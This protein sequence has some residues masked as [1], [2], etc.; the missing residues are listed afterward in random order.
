MT[1]LQ[2]YYRALGVNSAGGWPLSLFLTPDAKPLGG[3]TYF[4]PTDEEGRMGFPSLMKRVVQSWSEKRKE[5][6]NNAEYLT[7]AVRETMRPRAVLKPPKLEAAIVSNIVNL[8][9]AT[10]DP[11]HGG[12]GF[13]AA[14]PRRPKF[15]VPTKLAL[16]Q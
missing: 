14:E 4:P 10:Y 7:T 12:F 5:M 16:L 3:G 8:L 13:N 1:A 6:E 2:T 9:Q 11:E 15:P